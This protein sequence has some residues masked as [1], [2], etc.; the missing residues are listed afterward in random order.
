M[1]INMPIMDGFQ[2]SIEI[3]E[4]CQNQRFLKPL[5]VALTGENDINVEIKCKEC[6]MDD[7]FTKPI[8]YD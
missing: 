3:A 4:L 5:I 1:D 7:M 8:N 6:G 2:A